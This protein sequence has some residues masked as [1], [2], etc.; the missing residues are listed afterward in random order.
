MC[1]ALLCLHADT[2]LWCCSAIAKSS[3]S[4]ATPSACVSPD[5]ERHVTL[6]SSLAAESDDCASR[7][8]RTHWGLLFYLSPTN[9]PP[10][11]ISATECAGWV[12]SLQHLDSIVTSDARVRTNSTQRR[13][14]ELATKDIL[15]IHTGR[16][17]NGAWTQYE[18]SKHIVNSVE[19]E[20]TA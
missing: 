7:S 1:C 6:L 4:S 8:G 10:A 18:Y 16:A 15:A 12:P 9:W 3:I 5:I 14:H 17:Y 2:H 11:C 19:A 20:D 13:L